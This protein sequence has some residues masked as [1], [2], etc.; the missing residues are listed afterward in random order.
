VISLPP[1][2]DLPDS[3]FVEDPAVVVPEVAIITR[4]GAESRRAEAESLATVLARYR[5]VRYLREPAT[6]EGGDVLR[7]EKTVFV[8][9]SQ[10]TN[11]EGIKQLASE[12]SPFGYSVRAVSVDRCLHLKSACSWLGKQ[13][14]LANAE[15]IDIGILEAAGL[16]IVPV[17]PCET[18]AANVLAI[19][20][21]VVVPAAFPE[22]AA[23]IAQL[24]FPVRTLDISELMKAEAGLTCSSIILST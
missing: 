22:T 3:M 20:G 16:R 5:P 7:I 13:T 21:T 23:L 12:L 11:M 2:P 15:W 1:E 18:R 24:G 14:V 19:N 8:G 6:L 4:M 10:R 17:P 9:S